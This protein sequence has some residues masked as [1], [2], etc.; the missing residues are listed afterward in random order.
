MCT[1]ASSSAWKQVSF[2]A[3]KCD[4]CLPSPQKQ[5]EYHIHSVPPHFLLPQ[6][7]R[8]R[9]RPG[10]IYVT[11]SSARAPGLKNTTDGRRRSCAWSSMD[12]DLSSCG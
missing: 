1:K 9:T 6:G 10:R 5:T 12:G 4:S 7:M 3:R 11:S 2:A 8:V